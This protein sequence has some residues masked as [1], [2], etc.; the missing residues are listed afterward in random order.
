LWS[1]KL[2]K[3]NKKLNIVKIF[4][5]LLIGFFDSTRGTELNPKLKLGG[6]PQQKF[7]RLTSPSRADGLGEGSNERKTKR[8][9]RNKKVF[10]VCILNSKTT[11][12]IRRNH[13]Q[14]DSEASIRIGE[15]DIMCA[16][17]RDSKFLACKNSTFQ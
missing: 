11:S 3:K 4:Y 12:P 1:S 6:A 7:V 5:S 16:K 2:H 17:L 8:Q 10:I 13:T 9:K 15:V 14:G